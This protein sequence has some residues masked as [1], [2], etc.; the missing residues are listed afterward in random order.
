VT[1]GTF[2]ADASVVTQVEPATPLGLTMTAHADPVAPSEVVIYELTLTNR[3]NTLA[4]QTEIRMPIPVGVGSCQAISDGGGTPNLCATGRDVAWTLGALPAGTSRAVQVSFGM[5]TVTAVPNGSI[6]SATARARDAA[7]SNA[8]AGLDISAHT[9]AAAPLMLGLADGPD[10][11]V[12]GAEVRYTLRFGNRGAVARLASQLALTLPA[13]ITVTDAGGGASGPADTL[14]WDLGTLDP[15][16]TDERVIRGTVTALGVGDPLVR[17]AHATLSSGATVARARAVTQVESAAPLRLTIIAQQDPVAPSGFLTY[18]VKVENAGP[19]QAVQ[20][21]LRMAIPVGVAACQAITDGGTTPNLCAT[22]RDIRWALGTIDA[23]AS[24]TVEATF[25]VASA[26]AAPNGT[27]LF[28]TARVQ[29][30]AGSRARA[31]VSTT[32]AA[33]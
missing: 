4:A 25:R 15:G 19:A 18:Q 13:G 31:T 9:A 30:A 27:V 23:G 29:D 12:A 7:G 6:V 33:N 28:A 10:P 5:G 14:T 16:E 22:G 32:V 26:T 3:G 2:V 1:S 11:A 20:P 17:V 21:E 8:R 24:K